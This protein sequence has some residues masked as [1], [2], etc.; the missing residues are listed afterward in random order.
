M[1]DIGRFAPNRMRFHKLKP[2][3]FYI[4]FISSIK[5]LRK[6]KL[7]H[8]LE[9]EQELEQVLEHEHEQESA[10]I[11]AR[12]FYHTSHT[13]RTGLSTLCENRS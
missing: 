13:T 12:C 6:N 1:N 4:F 5:S 11:L 2:F 3:H 7:E 10:F 9:L 8:E